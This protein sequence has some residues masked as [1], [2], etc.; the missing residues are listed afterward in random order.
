MLNVALSD[1]PI[2]ESWLALLKFRLRPSIEIG[3]VRTTK[4]SPDTVT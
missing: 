1:Y 2:V 4:F 3:E